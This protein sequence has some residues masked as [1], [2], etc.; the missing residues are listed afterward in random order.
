MNKTLIAGGVILLAVIFLVFQNNGSKK[1][2]N[3]E[4]KLVVTNSATNNNLT[5]RYVPYSKEAFDNLT[6]KKRVYFF[7]AKWCPT[8][9]VADKEFTNNSDKIPEDIVVFKT[10]YDTEKD[11]IAKYGITYQH[12]FVYVDSL[13][14]EVKKWNGGGIS[15]LITNIENQ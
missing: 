11:L 1:N 14:G 8:C 4:K 6:N 2:I 13:G 3:K 15:E 7:H 9:K 5:D 12:T 10:D